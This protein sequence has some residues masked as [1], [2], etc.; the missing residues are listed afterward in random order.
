[1]IT[2]D[3]RI[4]ETDL[5]KK[6]SRISW[7]FFSVFS[8]TELWRTS[9]G[10]RSDNCANSWN[11]WIPALGL[12]FLRFPHSPR[13]SQGSGFWRDIRG[14]DTLSDLSAPLRSE[15]RKE[16][17]MPGKNDMAKTLSGRTKTSHLSLPSCQ[18]PRPHNK[19]NCH[20]GVNYPVNHS[21]KS[22]T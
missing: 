11:V 13:Q 22:Q 9:G 6:R 17:W 8:S 15:A 18:Q 19:S 16:A 7:V 21:M 2:G 20:T 10:Q 4:L 5:G 1:M 12:S 14:R 3:E